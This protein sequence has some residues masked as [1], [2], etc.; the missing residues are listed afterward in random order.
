MTGNVQINMLALITCARTPVM[1]RMSL[2]DMKLNAKFLPT[3]P[4]V[5]AQQDGL[6]ILIRNA[7][8]VG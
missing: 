4:F 1:Y 2:V 7:T 6:E 5:H 3:G 8:P